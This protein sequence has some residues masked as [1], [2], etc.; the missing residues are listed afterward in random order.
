MSPFLNSGNHN[1]GLYCMASMHQANLFP[2]LMI[3]PYFPFPHPFL[4]YFCLAL[5]NFYFLIS[6]CFNCLPVS[7]A[8]LECIL[9]KDKEFCL[10]HLLLYP[11]PEA[12]SD[13]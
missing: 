9:H 6:M 12:V 8:P 4:L 2:I 13:T 1:A 11:S 7:L 5:R 10:M 3:H